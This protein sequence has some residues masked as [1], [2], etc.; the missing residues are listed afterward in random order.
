[1]EIEIGNGDGCEDGDIDDSVGDDMNGDG[2]L[3]TFFNFFFKNFQNFKKKAYWLMNGL[4]KFGPFLYYHFN[5]FKG[6]N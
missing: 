5:M 3:A 6:H 4:A 1:M 2:Q